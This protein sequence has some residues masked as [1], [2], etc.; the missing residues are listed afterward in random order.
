MAVI[1]VN[2]TQQV[3]KVADSTNV[4]QANQTEQ[5]FNYEATE[6]DKNMG[7]VVEGKV[8]TVENDDSEMT[9]LGV[10][11]AD[12]KD[13]FIYIKEVFTKGFKEAEL[14]GSKKV[15]ERHRKYIEQNPNSILSLYSRRVCSLAIKR[16]EYLTQKD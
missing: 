2:G 11:N 10:I 3:A 7:L 8:Q 14:N 12:V 1:A 5:T 15:L 13:H 4:Q 16:I 9:F 6:A